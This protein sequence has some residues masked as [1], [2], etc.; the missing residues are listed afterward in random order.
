MDIVF[1]RPWS[2]FFAWNMSDKTSGLDEI[3][4]DT[5]CS[6][7]NCNHGLARDCLKLRCTC[8][9]KYDHNMVLDGMIGYGDVHKK[10][11]ERR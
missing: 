3:S 8:C 2:G 7:K 11:K 4:R 9:K 6:C 5:V 10:S 1:V